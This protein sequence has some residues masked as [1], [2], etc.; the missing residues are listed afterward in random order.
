MGA[1]EK[2]LP[3]KSVCVQPQKQLISQFLIPI[4]FNPLS[5]VSVDS[6]TL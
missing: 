3:R 2:K 6:S 1:G 5:F 4:I